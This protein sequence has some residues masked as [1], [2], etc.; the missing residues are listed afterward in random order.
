MKEEQNKK[1][2]KVKTEGSSK[3]RE[4]FTSFGFSTITTAM[5]NYFSSLK[6]YI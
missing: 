6:I 1:E 3:K 5:V 4:S 2:N